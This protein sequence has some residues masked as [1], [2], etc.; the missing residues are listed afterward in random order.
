VKVTLRPAAFEAS[1]EIKRAT[2]SRDGTITF[3]TCD[4]ARYAV[5]VA[6]PPDSYVSAIEFNRQDALSHLVDM[7]SG[8]GGELIVKVASGSA[9]VSGNIHADSSEKPPPNAAQRVML[10][11]DN[12]NPEVNTR[13]PSLLSRDGT[14]SIKGQPPGRYRLIAVEW[15]D[16]TWRLRDEPELIRFLQASGMAVELTAGA[17]LRIDVPLLPDA[18]VMQ[19]AIR[20]GLN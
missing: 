15:S 6:P 3:P 18:E 8:N 10:I 20:L 2:V 5:Q 19:A 4:A 16:S 9:G 7:T 1:S 14:Y 17:R 13:V 11:P 12:W